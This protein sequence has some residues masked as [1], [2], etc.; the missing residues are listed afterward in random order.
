MPKIILG[1]DP[2]QNGSVAV[3]NGVSI[4]IKKMP[5]TPTDLLNF[6]K[7]FSKADCVCYFEKVHGQPGMGGASMF[8][9][10]KNFGHIE[11]ALIAA[12]IK[13]VT[14]SPQKWQKV[15]SLG[16]KS[17]CVS[18]TEWKNK[19]KAKAQQLFPKCQIF[20]WGADAALIAQYGQMI[21]K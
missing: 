14:I 15:F 20:L 2:G 21:E 4:F 8:T 17:Q 7:S 12:G 11:M 19:L 10:G 13:T 16:T 1:I 6:L 18:G 3:L 5:E 9:F